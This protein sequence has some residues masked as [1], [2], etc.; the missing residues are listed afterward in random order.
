MSAINP[1]KRIPLL[2]IAALTLLVSCIPVITHTG[3]VQDGYIKGA[4]VCVDLNANGACDS[5]EPTTT[6][7]SKGKYALS[8]VKDAAIVAYVGA[9]AIDLESGDAI[10]TPYTMVAPA[11]HGSVVNPLTTLVHALMLAD[12]VD[13]ATAEAEVIA[14]LGLSVDNILGYD[15]QAAD[16]TA[17]HAVAQTVAGLLADVQALTAGSQTTDVVAK[18]LVALVNAIGQAIDADQDWASVVVVASDIYAVNLDVEGN[19]RN[20][21][22]HP[23]DVEVIAGTGYQHTL[24][25]S[26][27]NKCQHCHN[28][29][30]DTWQKSMHAQ[31][32]SDP[33]FQ[34]LYQDFLRMGI[35]NIGKTGPGGE[36]TEAKFKGV[37]QTCIKCHAPTAFYSGDFNVQLDVLS[38]DPATDYTTMKAS[39]ESNTAPAYDPSQVAKVVSL[40]NN[41]KVYRA[42]YHIGN[43][44]NREG[45]SCAFC[46]SVETVRL[47]NNITGDMGEYKLK[48]NLT[49]GPIGPIV[50]NAGDVL[51]YDPSSGN[52]DMN[53]FFMLVGPEKY[54]DFGNTPKTALDFDVGKTV[55]GRYTMK[56][57]PV[58]KY[59][60]GPFYGPYGVTGEENSRADDTLDR[61]ALVNQ[62]FVDAGRNQHMEDYGKGFCLSCHQRSASALN[63]ES[64]GQAGVQVGDDQFM[65]LC[66]TWSA[67]SNSATNDN[68]TDTPDSPKCQKCHM[69]RVDNKVVLHKWNDPAT[70]F[71]T[72]E[73]TSEYFDPASGKGPVALGYLNNHAFMGANVKD[74][75]KGKIMSGFNASLAASA[76]ADVVTVETTLQN[77]TAHM[78]PGAHPMRR[79][80]TRVVVT[81][82]DGTRLNYAN[83]TGNSTFAT[84]TDTP[85]ATLPGETIPVGRDK[86]TVV[87]DPA[88]VISFPGLEPDLA[89]DNVNSQQFDNSK[90]SWEASF[91]T[92]TNHQVVDNAGVWSVQG[93]VGVNK[94]IDSPDQNHFTRIYGRE[95]G[96]KDPLNS[97]TFVVRPG[98]DSNIARDNRLLPNEQEDYSV[99][100]DATAAV[101]PVSVTY[102]VYYMAKGAGGAFPTALTDGFLDEAVATQKKLGIY[103][104]YS[105]TVVIAEQL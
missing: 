94:I 102:K 59:T 41:G 85:I 46:H 86:A 21:A 87:Y 104:V 6:S 20:A 69:E 53:A 72:D 2:V 13:A 33:V 101:Y 68:Y 99:E 42:S 90:V 80:L 14:V 56:S 8:S 45:I 9:G 67:M 25:D 79:V 15:Y 47:M 60:G 57:I 16:D 61:H 92:A 54:S 93:L 100:F 17:S 31:S 12:G 36:Y 3:V 22:G 83:A 32:W 82:A 38:T 34:T 27:E 50:R 65:E 35:S 28:D 40:S 10:T 18:A 39:Q 37:A 49:A 78:F 74:F 77:R 64:N 81:D 43:K 29:L 84:I 66:T 89:G 19:P 1:F 48:N 88:R 91:G 103:E 4:T 23:G 51:Y 73:V 44:H 11:G 105:E 70:L 71:T 26:A 55:D 52:A 58:G 75:G 97:N 98:F 95:T 76:A 5:G 96:K 62:A 63:P 7:N 24:F 30:Y